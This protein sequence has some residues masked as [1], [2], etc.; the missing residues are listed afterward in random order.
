[1]RVFG[2]LIVAWSTTAA[3]Y[4]WMVK[5]H[6]GSCAACHVDPSG[7]GQLTSFGRTESERLVRWTPHPPAEGQAVVSPRSNF[8]WFLELPDA[9]NL[10]G[11]LRFGAL[12]A[13]GV[14]PTARPLEKAVDLS[15]TF[16]IADTLVVHGTGGFGRGDALA[17]AIVAPRCD[18]V[19]AGECGA[20][21]VART[22][23]VGLKAADGAVQ[24]RGGRL[25]VPFG[26]RNIEHV[27]WVRALTLTDINVQQRLGVAA[28]YNSGNLRAEVMGFVGG[29]LPAYR[30]GGYSALVEYGFSPTAYLGLS[31]LVAHGPSTLPSLP[32][33]LVTRHAHG[34]FFRWSPV[35]PLALLAEADLLLWAGQ[36]THAG[37]AA[38]AQADWE[39]V[40]GL[41]LMLT[42]E[43]AH[44]GSDQHGASLGGWVSAAWYF[45]S[46]CELRLDNVVRREDGLSGAF[47]A[48]VVQLHAYL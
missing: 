21:F 27:A 30:E 8:L 35:S 45:F 42:A 15:A 7:G 41:H 2:L 43:S 33:Q 24:V 38:F 1:M 12:V 3:A 25:A 11:N 20:S 26:L 39:V 10:S 32:D 13:P 4:P 28:S 46:H 18:P 22:Y 17:P 47:Y 40:Q 29:L 31:S 48:L 5:N 36:E 6:Y 44:R 14:D 34:A 19:T 16:T 9:V 37:F 23:W